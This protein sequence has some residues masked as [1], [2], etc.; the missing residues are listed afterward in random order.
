MVSELR[1]SSVG[2]PVLVLKEWLHEARQSK[3][4]PNPNTMS[5]ST[6]DSMSC[7][8]S[9]MVL[10]KEINEDLGYLVFYT[11]Y[12]SEKSKEI[13]SHNNCSAL[14]LW[15]PLVYQ[16]RVRGK[17]IKSPNHESDNY[18]ST[19]K[20][21]S[22]LSAWAS[23]QSDEV[24]NRESLDDQFQKI[25][26]RFNIQD[27]DLDSTEIE[28]PRPDFWGGYRIWINEIELWLNQSERFHD[29]LSFKRDLV[30]TSS[31]FNAENNWVVKRLQP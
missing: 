29:R 8:N 2:N 16:V 6:V 25:M 28:I 22:Q 7:P 24:E 19:R 12:N 3:I 31:G 9:R 1:K 14:F 23:N 18:F 10:C 11:N 4:Q 21:G 17:L 13:E 26:K 5:I 20:V 27:E 30:K 15:D